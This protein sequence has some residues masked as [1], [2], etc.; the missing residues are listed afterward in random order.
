M[1]FKAQSQCRATVEALAEITNPRAVAFVK[2]DNI[3]N[4]PQQVNNGEQAAPSRTEEKE[5]KPN[6][7]LEATHGERLDGGAQSAAGGA[8]SELETVGAINGAAK[9]RR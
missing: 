7:L 6:K 4:G 2:Q 8:N 9:C 5:I 3:A 1:A